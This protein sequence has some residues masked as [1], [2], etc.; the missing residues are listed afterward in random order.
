MTIGAAWIYGGSD[1]QQLW[2]ASDSR[3]SGD[4]NIWDDCPKLMSL[5]RRDAIA[6]FS[7]ET[8]QAYPLLLQ[9][10]NAVATYRAAA[11]GTLAFFHL[12]THLEHIVNSMMDH[13]YTDPAVSGTPAITRP[14]SSYGDALVLGGYA[15]ERNALVIRALRYSGSAQQ[16]KFSRVRSRMGASQQRT[17]AIFGDSKAR[18]RFK[19]FL[20][21]HMENKGTYD[22]DIPFKLEPLEVI[23]SMLKMPES[24][25]ERIPLGSRPATIGGVPQVMQLYPGGQATPIAVHWQGNA[26]PG[27]YV[28]GR[29]AFGYERL[30]VPLI[31]FTE[32]GPQ[33]HARDNWPDDIRRIR[34]ETVPGQ[35]PDSDF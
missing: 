3:L 5:P 6:A 16:W 27:V 30:N 18:P 15:R 2:F 23:A 17:L 10:S 8:A 20:R 35:E 1:S 21:Q 12:L 26:G 24:R 9:L 32:D 11:D 33:I 13:V 34:A 19:Y 14:F 31:T 25:L 29:E 28:L 7:G 22:R 4:G